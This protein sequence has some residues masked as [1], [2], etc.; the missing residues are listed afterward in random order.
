MNYYLIFFFLE[1]KV[2][3]PFTHQMASVHSPIFKMAVLPCPKEKI[4]MAVPARIWY[5][6]MKPMD[7]EIHELFRQ[8]FPLGYTPEQLLRLLIFTNPEE[9]EGYR[10]QN[11]QDSLSRNL[12]NF[13][14][15]KEG[16]IW[17]LKTQ[18]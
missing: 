8:R 16:N 1:H 6:Q 2:S 18:K 5:C 9:H 3:L 17:V 15:K 7:K 10:V 13:V 11:V 12:N 4:P 14:E